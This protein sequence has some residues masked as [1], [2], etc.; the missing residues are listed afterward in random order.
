M[1]TL[2]DI[3]ACKPVMEEDES[4]IEAVM[5]IMCSKYDDKWIRVDDLRDAARIWIKEIMKNSKKN[6]SREKYRKLTR[7]L[8]EE[9]LVVT[10][11]NMI[12]MDVSKISWIKH[13][14]NLED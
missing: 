11:D 9:D 8:K 14:F 3:E 12:Y 7:L 10:V 13:F 4:R 5:S 1:K 6:Y 2:K